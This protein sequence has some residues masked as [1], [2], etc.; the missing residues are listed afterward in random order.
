MWYNPLGHTTIGE[1][2]S[3]ILAKGGAV[4]RGA[5]AKSRDDGWG[6]LFLEF[7]FMREKNKVF[8]ISL[9]MQI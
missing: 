4:V 3:P 7:L 1:Q 6:R 9:I 2:N 8:Y 5:I